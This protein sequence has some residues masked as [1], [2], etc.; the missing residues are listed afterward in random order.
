MSARPDL[1]PPSSAVRDLLAPGGVLR[2]GINLSNFLLVTGR[3]EAGDP[4]GVSPDMARAFADHLGVALKL[5]PY[6]SPG[7]VADAASRD[8]WDIANIGAEPQRAEVIAFTPAYCEIEATYLVPAGSPL[9][10]VAE[11]DAPGIEIAVTR[12]TA[13]G[14]WL[15]RNV[16]HATLVPSESM[17]EALADFID[18]KRDALAGLRP[19]LLADLARVPGGRL[20]PGQYAAVQQAI[21]TPKAKAAALDEIVRFVEAAKASGFVA[22]L[23]ARHGVEGK[24]GVAPAA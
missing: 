13:Y 10:A 17:A 6:A 23:I 4:V 7:L 2:A 18:N 20:L 5:V 12:R 15:E 21:G 9:Q 19:G 3:T 22:G 11:V 16:A 24:L 14:L 8:E 1:A